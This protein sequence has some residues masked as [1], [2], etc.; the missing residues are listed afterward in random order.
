MV[1]RRRTSEDC[2]KIPV[3]DCSTLFYSQWLGSFGLI[4]EVKLHWFYCD[5]FSDTVPYRTS[6]KKYLRKKIFHREIVNELKTKD[7]FRKI[8]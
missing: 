4:C 7:S 5:S 2:D 1:L 6:A 8:S 3:Q